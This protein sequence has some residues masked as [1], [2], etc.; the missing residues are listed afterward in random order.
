MVEIAGPNTINEIENIFCIKVYN[1][2]YLF[3][4]AY[5]FLNAMETNEFLCNSQEFVVLT[6]ETL[7]AKG[8]H[9]QNK[10]VVIRLIFY[11]QYVTY[12]TTHIER[13]RVRVIAKC[14]LLLMKLACIYLMSQ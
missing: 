7:S 13:L 10:D 14:L 1:I 9:M 5:Y 12:V 4:M 3:E 6:F 2:N 8:I 11:T